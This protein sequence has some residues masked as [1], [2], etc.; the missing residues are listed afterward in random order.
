MEELEARDAGEMTLVDHLTELRSVLI[1]SLAAIAIAAAFPDAQ[2]DVQKTVD[3]FPAP[4][5][6]SEG[7]VGRH[8]MD[9]GDLVAQEIGRLRLFPEFLHRTRQLRLRG[10]EHG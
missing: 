9:L 8:G 6:R 10:C 7:A 2:V 4:G 5:Q 3:G 1:Q